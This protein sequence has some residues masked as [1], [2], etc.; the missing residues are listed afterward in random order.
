MLVKSGMLATDIGSGLVEWNAPY[1]KAQ[2]YSTLKVCSETGPYRGPFW[3]ERAKSEYKR[4][5]ISST[6]R[7]A[8]GDR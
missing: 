4:H 3:F 6:R 2:Y 1:A 8:G 5:W 7:I